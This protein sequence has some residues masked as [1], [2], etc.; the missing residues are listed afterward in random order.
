MILVAI[1]SLPSIERPLFLPQYVSAAPL[2]APSPADL[3]SCIKTIT[4][5]A[6]LIMINATIKTVFNTAISN[7]PPANNTAHNFSHI[8]ISWYIFQ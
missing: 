8:I 7:T 1:T 6:I 3:P 2:I 5:N 4:V